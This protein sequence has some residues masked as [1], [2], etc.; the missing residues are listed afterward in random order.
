MRSQEQAAQEANPNLFT[1]GEIG[2]AAATALTYGRRLMPAMA[3]RGLMGASLA[4]ARVGALEGLGYGF[5]S[6]EGGAGE[7]AK[8]A[9][10]FGLLGAGVG[11][12]VPAATALATWAGQAGKDV[13]LGVPDYLR[14]TARQSRANRAL[15]KTLAASGRSVDDVDAALQQAAREGQPEFR[16]MDALG[17]SGQRR[18]SA[19]ARSGGDGATEMREFLDARQA[20]QPER[21]ASALEDAYDLRGSTAR[22]AREALEQGRKESA[23]IAFGGIRA[24]GNPVDVRP[25]LSALDEKI[26]PYDRANISSPVVKR[27]KKLRKQLAGQGADGSY[28]LSDF[29]KVFTIR[30]EL[31][32]A[33]SEAYSQGKSE[34]GRALKDVR[35][36]MDEA[37]SASS[38]EYADAM[39]RYATASR[40]IDAVQSGREMARPGSRAADSARAF[41]GMTG[42]QQAAA[43]AGYGDAALARVEASAGGANRARPLTSPKAREEA[44]AMAVDNDVFQRRIGREMDMFETRN[45][46]AG[47][48][49]TADNLADMQDLAGYDLTP[50]ANVATG[51]YGV[52]AGQ[53]VGQ[54]RDVLTGMND[55]TRKLITDALMAGDMSAFRNALAQVERVEARQQV[56]NIIARAGL[57]RTVEPE[58]VR[59]TVGGLRTGRREADCGRATPIGVRPRS[60][61]H[62]G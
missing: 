9:A 50:L 53:V 21:V 55:S 33:I 43:R 7:R 62:R 60:Q 12:V 52:A 44:A 46:A 16:A 61:W 30:K 56:M 10:Q 51:N 59:Q 14:N 29:D 19:V 58:G 8:N 57:L 37:L 48:S 36:A 13:V 23:D 47:G 4:G 24:T 26:A 1:A 28:E 42:D 32:D 27:L 11:S 6:G 41:S 25:V 40:T 17:I 5:L 49:R 22:A 38:D 2:G 45:I 54:L 35:I 15:A 18:A 3:L 39:R 31:K 20:G 34:M